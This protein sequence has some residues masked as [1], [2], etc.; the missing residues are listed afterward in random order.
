MCWIWIWVW[1]CNRHTPVGISRGW[2]ERGQ[3]NC[4]NFNTLRPR[5]N[6]YRFVDD[7]FKRIFLNEDIRISIKISLKFVPQGPINN[8]PALVQIMAWRRSGDKPLCEPM[9]AS[10]LTHICVTRPQWVN[11]RLLKQSRAGLVTISL[12]KFSRTGLI[13]EKWKPHS[14]FLVATMPGK[15]RDVHFIHNNIIL[16]TLRISCWVKMADILGAI[17]S[18]TLSWL[19]HCVSFKFISIFPRSPT[20]KQS[21]LQD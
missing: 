6:G 8:N 19:H 2:R 3:F 17:F 4:L 21:S 1:I 20:S 12:C 9:M 7:T 14:C 11:S 10:L 16:N 18:Y 15:V 5:Q 13:S